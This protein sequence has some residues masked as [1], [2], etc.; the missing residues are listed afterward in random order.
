LNYNYIVNYQIT[1]H[2]NI[3][4]EF[5]RETCE[6]SSALNSQTMKMR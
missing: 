2:Q 6:E 1:N 4:K 3:I 5:M